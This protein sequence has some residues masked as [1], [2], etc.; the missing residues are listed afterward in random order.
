M[1]KY[2]GVKKV[3]LKKGASYEARLAVTAPSGERIYLK[4]RFPTAAAANEWRVAELAKARSGRRTPKSDLT[5]EVA[6]ASWLASRR[7][8]ASTVAAYAAALAPVV[9]RFGDVKAQA[10]SREMVE[11]LIADLKTGA[12]PGGRKWARTSINPMLAR[13][14]A[15]WRDLHARKVIE[16]DELQFIEPLRKR[17]DEDAPEGAMDISDRLSDEEVT[18]LIGL[19]GVERSIE[20][21]TVLAAITA[22]PRSLPYQVMTRA[23]FVQLALLGL[24]RGEL[25]GL[26]WGDVDLEAGTIT[27]AARTRT[28][29]STIGKAGERG[30]TVTHD[31]KSGKTASATRTLPLPPSLIPMLTAARDR[32]RRW[33][34]HA[35]DAWVGESGKDM[36]LF[37]STLGKPI[38]PRTLDDWWKS[39][40]ADAGVPHRRL[41]A[42]RHTAASRLFAAGLSPAQVAAWLGHADGGV[43][44]LRVYTHVEKEELE[45]AATVFG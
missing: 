26:R 13:L 21:K 3:E 43:L 5:V 33:R 7:V 39:A 16:V 45:A 12:G 2:P 20:P 42:S 28:T 29:V 40:L 14:K 24:R 27:V 30:A 17:D 15:V 23:P 4:E 18:K 35:G 31:R 10:L 25:A 44:A 8:N 36:H 34:R 37:T 1:A 22:G 32:Q 6:I 9:E 38:A 19:F 11:G 41:H